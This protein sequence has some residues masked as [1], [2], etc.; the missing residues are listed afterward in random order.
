MTRDRRHRVLVWS[1]IGVASLLLIVSMTANWVQRTVLDSNEVAN[2]S[3]Q[4]L[5]DQDVQEALSIYLVDQLYATVDVQG[6]IE[7]SLPDS[8]K[9]LSA[10][11]AAA[12]RRL[13]LDVSERA[14]ATPG[15]QALVSTAIRDGHRQFVRLVR[16]RDG[17]VSSTDGKVT[18][19]YGDL[20]SELAIRLGVEPE[21]ID[22]IR[23]VVQEASTDLKQSLTTVQS[24]LESARSELDRV[25]GGTL[26]P[27]VRQKL[28][29]LENGAAELQTKISELTKTIEGAQEKVP[30]QLE[31]RLAKFEGRLSDLDGRLN[32]LEERTAA[33]LEDPS[34]ANTQELDSSLALVEARVVRLLGRPLIQSP[35]QL[36]LIDSNQLDAV[37]TAVR[38]LRNL[39]FVLP[40][41]VLLLYVG[42][43]YLARGWRRQTLIAAGG[44]ILVSMLLVLLIRRLTGNAVVDSL[45]GSETVEPAVRSVWDIV[46]GGL[47]ERALFLLVIGVAFV[48]AGLLAGPGRHAT[49]TRRFLAPYLRDQPVLVYSVIAAFFILWLTFIPG[50]ENLGQIIAIVAL[51]ALAV[52]GVEALRRQ[53]A[54]EFPPGSSSS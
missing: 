52:V 16:D 47:R 24:Q 45:S 4:I 26:D 15:F 28:E 7:E 12:G 51:A 17:Y 50:I 32:T 3:D 48:G 9:A 18:L 37:Q 19:N 41:L 2:T 34:Q 49:S 25:Q 21:T 14:L 39:G 29:S 11:I 38:L 54:G 44:G 23:K 20:I 43:I 46:S 53:T 33:V 5:A 8:A 31:S 30:A 10:P 27:E 22:E 42:A 13:A 36:V 6:Q 1:L 35:G 40:I